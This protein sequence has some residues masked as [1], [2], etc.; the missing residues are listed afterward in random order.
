MMGGE[1]STMGIWEAPVWFRAQSLTVG[2]CWSAVEVRKL[3]YHNVSTY[4]YIYV[5]IDI[6]NNTVSPK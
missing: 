3:S 4:I 6:V 2:L 5:Y 1:D